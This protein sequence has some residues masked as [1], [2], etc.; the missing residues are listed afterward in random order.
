LLLVAWD[1]ESLL[2]PRLAKQTDRLDTVH[3][4]TLT[5]NGRYVRSYY[6]R[7]AHGYRPPP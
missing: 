2:D 3:E 6:Y 7:V 4:A 5:R 1:R